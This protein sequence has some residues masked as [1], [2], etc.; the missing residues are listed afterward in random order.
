MQL[1]QPEQLQQQGV[2]SKK[3]KLMINAYPKLVLSDEWLEESFSPSCRYSSWFHVIKH[4]KL[5]HTVPWAIREL[6]EQVVHV[7]PIV[8]NPT[9][10]EFTLREARRHQQK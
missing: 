6:W 8:A 7:D 10:S 4:D 1:L 2:S 9:V 5:D 3:A